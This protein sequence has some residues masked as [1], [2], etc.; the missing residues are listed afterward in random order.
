[1]LHTDTR[2]ELGVSEMTTPCVLLRLL[3]ATVHWHGSLQK[4]NQT[5]RKDGPRIRVARRIGELTPAIPQKLSDCPSP[6]LELSVKGMST[7]AASKERHCSGERTTKSNSTKVDGYT[8][9]L[10]DEWSCNG[11]VVTPL[12]CKESKKHL[13]I[14]RLTKWMRR[15]SL[16]Y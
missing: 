14:K 3:A 12:D 9:V 5:E 8:F 13:S 16:A 6:F 10:L 15:T 4:Q 11:L 2:A 1:M 7:S